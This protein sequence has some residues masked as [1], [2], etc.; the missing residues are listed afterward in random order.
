MNPSV[1]SDQTKKNDVATAAAPAPAV[2]RPS[3]PEVEERTDVVDT[4]TLVLVLNGLVEVALDGGRMFSLAAGDALDPDYKAL[5]A[6]H[7]QERTQFARELQATVLR[8]GGNPQNH[9]TLEGALLQAWMDV[10]SAVAVREDYAVLREVERAEQNA[11]KRYAR[12]LT[13]DLGGDVK[14]LVERQYSAVSRS[15]D[16]VRALRQKHALRS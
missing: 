3:A 11:R 13:L 9:G 2:P 12:A 6:Q 10:K 16:R 7:A 8:L 1:S 4:P 5:F 15:H 14:A